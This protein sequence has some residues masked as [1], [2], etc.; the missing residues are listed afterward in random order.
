MNHSYTEWAI[1]EGPFLD[2]FRDFGEASTLYPLAGQGP[3]SLGEVQDVHQAF[4][5]LGCFS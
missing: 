1:P 3:P 4:A 5:G 2:L